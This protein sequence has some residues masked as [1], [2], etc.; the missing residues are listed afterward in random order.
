MPWPPRWPTL[1]PALALVALTWYVAERP[2]TVFVPFA[3]LPFARSDSGWGSGPLAPEGFPDCTREMLELRVEEPKGDVNL[4]FRPRPG[5]QCGIPFQ[6]ESWWVDAN[7][8]RYEARPMR[9]IGAIPAGRMLLMGRNG[10]QD[11]GG[12]VY[13]CDV[14]PPVEYF[15][16]L[17]GESVHVGTARKPECH[18]QGRRFRPS[19]L[20]YQ[21][22]GIETPAGWLDPEI[23][24]PQVTDEGVEFALALRNDTDDDIILSRCPFVDVSFTTSGLV[25][26]EPGYRT[27]LNC[28]AAPDRI[29]SGDV[30]LFG[31]VAPHENEAGVGTLHVVLRDESRPLHRLTTEI[32]S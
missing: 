23:V 7:G 5:V 26:D 21:D 13:G 15:V 17:A 10:A 6:I 24:D 19:I 2:R 9:V 3:N 22:G 27:F 18:G 32:G 1:I 25:P 16:E 11:G 8:E 4:T 31:I 29:E 12:T 20:Y 28:P 30:L 14:E